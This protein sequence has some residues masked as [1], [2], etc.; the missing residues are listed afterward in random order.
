MKPQS[1]LELLKTRAAEA[2]EFVG[3]MHGGFVTSASNEEFINYILKKVRK[4]N[5]NKDVQRCRVGIVIRDGGEELYLIPKWK[6]LSHD[7]VTEA[8]SE[9]ESAFAKIQEKSC[10]NIYLIFPKTERFSRH[11]ELK[12]SELE[13]SDYLLKLV[14]YRFKPQKGLYQ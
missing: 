5:P 10:V 7:P 8:R 13:G 2:E 12:Q 4:R 11:I 3:A 6:I 1:T 9:I 14:P